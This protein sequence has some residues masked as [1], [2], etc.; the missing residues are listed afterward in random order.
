M[1]SSAPAP[2]V[3]THRR[4]AELL[5]AP[6]LMAFAAGSAVLALALRD[7]HQEGSWGFCPFL[8][9]TGQPCPGCGGLR[10]VNNLTQLDVPAAVSS[11]AFVVV[12]MAAVALAWVA[13][14]VRRWRGDAGGMLRLNG[15]VAAV[16]LVAFLLFGIVRLTPWGAGLA[17]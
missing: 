12:A 13:W 11:N 2:G 17:P 5:L 4:R 16:L 6:G 10:A 1:T 8:M 7:P 3:L 9:L 14:V 15:R